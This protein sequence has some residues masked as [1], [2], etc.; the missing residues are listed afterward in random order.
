LNVWD[1]VADLTKYYGWGPK[2]AM[3]LPWSELAWWNAQAVRMVRSQS[4]DEQLTSG[5]WQT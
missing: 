5:S 3:D 1:L 2:E 4:V